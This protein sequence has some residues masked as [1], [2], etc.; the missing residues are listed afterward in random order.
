MF[1]LFR[2]LFIFFLGWMG[3]VLIYDVRLPVE[4]LQD[5]IS[6][7]VKNI[8][9]SEFLGMRLFEKPQGTKD[10]SLPQELKP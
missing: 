1:G 10:I 4:S 5:K 8:K 6:N 3:A 9:N 7:K 2:F